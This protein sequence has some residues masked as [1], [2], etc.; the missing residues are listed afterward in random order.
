LRLD[1]SDSL[2]GVLLQ[3]TGPAHIPWSDPRWQEL[4]YGY[5]VWVHVDVDNVTSSS[6]STSHA[7]THHIHPQH[8]QNNSNSSSN[9]SSV[10]EQACRSLVTHAARTSNLAALTMHVTQ[11]LRDMTHKDESND[12]ALTQFSHRIALV[13]KARATSGALKLLRIFIHA[14]LSC[15]NASLVQQA[16][17][18]HNRDSARTQQTGE[19]LLD[20]LL[21]FIA[22]RPSLPNSIPEMYD[23]VVLSMELLLVLFAKQLYNPFVS[24]FQSTDVSHDSFAHAFWHIAQARASQSIVTTSW[25]PR[26]LLATCLQWSL[27]RPVA[28]DRSIIYH[29]TYLKQS[30]ALAQGEKPHPSDGLYESHVIVQA[31]VKTH[32]PSESTNDSSRG[33]LSKTSA[34]QQHHHMSATNI[35]LDATRGVLVLSSNIIMLPLRLVSLALGLFHKDSNQQRHFDQAHKQHYLQATRF[36]RTKDVLWLS[37][38]PL[39]DMAT[40][41]LLLWLNTRRSD[42]SHPFRHELHVLTDN[43]W[44]SDLPDLPDSNGSVTDASHDYEQTPL[45]VSSSTTESSAM[46][47]SQQHNHLTANFQTLFDSFGRTAHSEVGALWLYTF[48]QSCPTFAESLAV[49]SDLDTLIVPLLRTLY[50]ASSSKHYA[51][52]D[53]ANSTVSIR[54]MPFR[55]QSQLYV[56]VI[57][58]LLFSQDSSFGSDAFR[59]TVVSTVPW[60]KERHLKDINLGSILILSL[61]RLLTFNLNRLHDAFLLSNCCAI[62]SNLSPSIVDIHEYTAMRLASMAVSSMKRYTTLLQ[63]HVTS[64]AAVDDDAESD[65]TQPLGMHAEVARTILHVIK[66]SLRSKHV[67]RNL[68]L[69]YALVYH[70]ADLNRIFT[71]KGKCHCAY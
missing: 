34:P 10:L 38:S 19:E 41:L 36:S 24:S 50:F 59:R 25:T 67:D 37:D 68:Y 5:D 43:R 3:V 33:V 54:N 16:F 61:L 40:S 47:V 22:S 23:A 13:T 45:R 49:R 42:L 48:I 60:Y 29:T 69:V 9:N 44:S 7:S 4:L 51:A 35:I 12:D 64:G 18:Y 31:A 21:D 39:A 11:Y 58:I 62:L 14:V 63:E 17:T 46:S 56:I 71:G 1:A 27:E 26:T 53:Y 15:D 55:S 2:A 52:A 8:M 32:S 70:R 20:G 6:H 66:S 30:V 65:L 28:P 57:L